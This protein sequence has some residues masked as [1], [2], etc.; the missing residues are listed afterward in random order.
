MVITFNTNSSAFSLVR[1]LGITQSQLAQS[2]ER[3]AS[4]F[5]I[6]RAA[7]DASGLAISERMRAQ[8]RGAQQGIANA[9]FGVSMIQT[10]DGALGEVNSIL[11]RMRELAVEASGGTLSGAERDAI[12]AELVTLRDEID[13]IAGRTTF[14]SQSLLTGAFNIATASAIGPINDGGDDDTVDVG[15]NVRVADA[16]TTYN[17]TVAGNDVT[18]TNAGNGEFQTITAADLNGDGSTAVL[19]FDQLGVELNLTLNQGAFGDG[20]VSAADIAAGLNGSAVV[21]TG[22]TASTTMRVGSDVGDVGDDISVSFGTQILSRTLGTE[23]NEQLSDLIRDDQAVSTIGEANTLLDSVD[24]A[25]D[26][27][28]V[29]RARLGGSQNQLGFAIASQESNVL[30]LT[31]AESR[32]RDIDVATEAVRFASLEVQ[33]NALLALMAQANIRQEGLL[34]LLE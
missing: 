18:V 33:Y 31:T 1:Y 16:N 9:Q 10:A 29:E 28:N 25:L 8:I 20:A 26:Q 23:P 2:S 4:S 27:V 5:R 30:N 32:I 17:V 6:N 14:N 11:Q 21:T 19:D 15:I 7:D 12:G 22:D 3:L 24:A 34:K 13:N